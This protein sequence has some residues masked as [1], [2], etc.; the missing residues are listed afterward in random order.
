MRVNVAQL[1]SLISIV[2]LVLGTTTIGSGVA[3]ALP[4]TSIPSN[5]S[6]TLR[7][8][9]NVCPSVWFVGA[10]GSGQTLNSSEHDMGPEVSYMDSV[11]ES[12]LS[13]SGVSSFGWKPVEYPAA[14][15][16]LL[17]P[18]PDEVLALRVAANDPL[19]VDLAVPAIEAYI[20]NHVRPYDDS[21]DAGING[22][23]SAVRT[24]VDECP[25]SEIV[26]AG[27]SQGAIA[28]HDAE[29]SLA[30][31]SPSLFSHIAATLLLGD[32][33]RVPN[34]QAVLFG[35]ASRLSSG[36]RVYP[37]L[38]H[39][40]DVPSPA[41]TAEIANAG[42]VVADF[43]FRNDDSKQKVR[44]AISTHEAYINDTHESSLSCSVNIL[45]CAATWAATIVKPKVESTGL[46]GSPT[47]SGALGVPTGELVTGNTQ[48][49][50][51]IQENVSQ[52]DAWV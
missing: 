28:I 33:D 25:N 27:Y 29:N 9:G 39:A 17:A 22:A 4:I 44:T 40:R 26:M 51:A 15:A 35:T 32:G 10:R 43:S 11:V 23:E 19:A 36:I 24:A 5:L 16:Q 20:A 45:A 1:R 38:V 37:H 41:T 47:I 12:A 34:T 8:E 49:D 6:G 48:T 30:R 14:S 2:A 52:G 3:A 42:D 31:N 46:P 7:P 50:V 21:I 13:D 18:S